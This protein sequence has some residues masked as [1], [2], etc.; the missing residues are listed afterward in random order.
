MLKQSEILEA[1]KIKLKEII[2]IPVYLDEVKENYETPCFFLKLV[3]H[4]RPE[5]E[6]ANRYYNECLLGIA[7]F[8]QKGTAKASIFY[9][10][11]DAIIRKFWR[12]LKIGKRYIHFQQLEC[13]I[14]GQD[15]D[16]MSV[17]LP[18]NYFDY[19]EDEDLSKL[20]LM[21]KIYINGHTKK[22]DEV[23]F[24]YGDDEDGET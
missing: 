16:I 17:A 22:G 6:A 8:E 9:D 5:N 14:V 20:D 3:K 13:D 1:V 21:L 24:K 23:S 11:Q 18:F 10:V 19:D 4:T 2:N 7:Y 12:G 15:G